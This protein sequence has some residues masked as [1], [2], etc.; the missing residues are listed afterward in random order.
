MAS[1]RTTWAS[2]AHTNKWTC[3]AAHRHTTTPVRQ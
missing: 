2:V 1:Q 3:D